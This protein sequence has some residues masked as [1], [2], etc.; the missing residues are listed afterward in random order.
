MMNAL[1]WIFIAILA[2]LGIRCM[3]K[4]FVAE[5]LS[6]AAVLVGILAAVFLYR[7]AGLLFVGW[8][9]SAAPEI[10]PAILG[11]AAVFL[12]AFIIVKLIERLLEEGIEAARLGGVDRAL[13]LGLGLA[14]GL[15][16]VCL[17][18]IAMSLLEPDMKSVSGFSKSLHNSF[19]A[20]VFL[21][22]VGPELAKATQGIDLRAPEL[23][24]QLKAPALKTP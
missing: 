5:V 20:R 12:V 2:L 16:L 11:F 21:P 24:M 4:G 3:I 22:I 8:G 10:L 15:V 13:G 1:D 23:K 19:F 14:E 7:G 17:V 6:V 18:L 9:L